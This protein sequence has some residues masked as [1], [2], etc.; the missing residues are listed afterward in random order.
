MLTRRRFLQ[1][2]TIAAITPALTISCDSSRSAKALLRPDP[3]R[4]IDLPDGYSYTVVSRKN[5]PM[6]DGL[7]V[8]GAHDGMAAFEGNEG[9]LNLVCNHELYAPEINWGPFGADYARLPES[10]KT[11]LYDRGGDDTPSLGGT[12][13]TIYNPATLETERQ[14]LSLGGTEFNCAGGKTPWGS[15]LTCEES[16]E[17]AGRARTDGGDVFLRDLRHGYV[18]EVPSSATE[19]VE[20]IPLKDLGRF[21]H[22]AAA[23]HEPT[24]IVYMTEDRWHSLFYRFIPNVPGQLQKGG[25]LQALAISGQPSKK[26]H[27]WESRD[28]RVNETL[29]T[30][31]IDLQDVDTDVN[32]LRTRGASAGAVTFA[33]GEGLSVAGDQFAFTCT[34]GG[35]ARLGQVFTYKPSPYEGTAEEQ[36][37]PGGLTLIAEGDAS[38]LLKNCDNLTMAPWGDLLVCED[39]KYD[40]GGCALVGI[41]PDGSQYLLAHNAYSESELAGVCFS[42]NEKILFINI[43]YPGMTLAITGPWPG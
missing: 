17:D 2:V 3:N 16:F 14:F 25:R 40:N 18:F 31:W 32:D 30:Y 33:R 7:R 34:I 28:I 12:T 8:P 1:S 35:Q 11:R 42:P 38:S 4:V 23:V 36:S 15:W 13:T 21:E 24:G 19:L 43:Q 20:A 22:E 26:T 10:F 41:R 39:T 9:R 27:N 6:S 29:A 5:E 37:A